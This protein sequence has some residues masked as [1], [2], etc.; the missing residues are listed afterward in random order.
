MT[1]YDRF[2]DLKVTSWGDPLKCEDIQELLS[3]VQLLS[4][5][6]DDEGE[7]GGEEEEKTASNE[8]ENIE[9]ETEDVGPEE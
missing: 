4:E 7:K 8:E 9:G 3:E 5:A 2:G 1:V 6:K